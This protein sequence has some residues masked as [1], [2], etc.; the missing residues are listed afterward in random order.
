MPGLNLAICREGSTL[1]QYF[2]NFIF[3]VKIWRET[4]RNLSAENFLLRILRDFTQEFLTKFTISTSI[5]ETFSTSVHKTLHIK[6][7]NNTTPNTSGQ[8]GPY[9]AGLIESDGA[10]ITPK[11]Y[12]G[13]PSIY[14]SLQEKDR[15]FAEYL[16]NHLC[17]GSIQLEVSS[18]NAIRFVIRNKE[19]IIDIL[20]L[21]NGFFRTPKISKLHAMIDWVNTKPG[22]LF[23]PIAKLPLDSYQLNTNSW[24]AGFAEGDASF[25]IRITE[26]KYRIV[27]TTFELSQGRDDPVLFQAYKPIM[28]IIASFLLANLGVTL[29]SQFNRTG[30]QPLWRARNSSQAG[31]QIVVNYFT[32]FPLLT[33]K[34]LDFVGWKKAYMLIVSKAH[35]K[36]NGEEGF[37][38][39][40]SIKANNN[41]NRTVFTWHHLK[42]MYTR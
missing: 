36:K 22:Y 20:N 17:Y 11:N 2:I 9:L 21:I 16:K 5:L 30:K 41:K 13:T 42:D 23:K 37:N 32:T 3:E 27:T 29:V 10:L 19:G 33:S 14:I 28:E 18:P 35:L 24:L 6:E 38:L 31:S 25:Q 4:I 26:G 15:P 34:Y 12:S 39:I 7:V 1:L 8:L 40:K